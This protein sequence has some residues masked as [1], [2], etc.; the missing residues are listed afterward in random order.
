MPPSWPALA[1]DLRQRGAAGAQD[2]VVADLLVVAQ[3]VRLDRRAGPQQGHAAAGQDAFFDGRAGGVQGV[4]D[5]GLL[6]LHFAFGRGADVDLGHAAGQLGQPLFELLAIVVAGDV[7]SISRRICS[8]R[9]LIS[10]L[11]PAPS[12]IV[13]LSLSMIDL[14][15]AAQVGQAD[16]FE[17]DAEVFEDGLP[18]VRMAMSSS[19]ALRRSP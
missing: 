18:P 7:F 11:L 15:G 1:G 14:L 9:P 13:V 17:L 8:M 2:D 16:V 3:P 10:A 4:F 6:L 5:A 12:M 19:M